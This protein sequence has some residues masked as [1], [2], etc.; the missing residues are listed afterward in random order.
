MPTWP[1]YQIE[2]Q[3]DFYRPY[4]EGKSIGSFHRHWGNF[5]HKVRCYTYLLRLGHEGIRR[6][7][8]MAVLSARYVQ[9]QLVDDYALMPTGA[10]N[11]P[12]MHEF[13]VYAQRG[14]LRTP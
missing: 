2:K 3:G 12:R 10:D 4:K 6:M 14:R 11:E 8:A 5:A 9:Q 1:G 7:S 13:I